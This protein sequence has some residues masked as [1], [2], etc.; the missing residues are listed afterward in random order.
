MV[1]LSKEGIL[2]FPRKKRRMAWYVEVL[3]SE[4]RKLDQ[5]NHAD[6]ENY[7]DEVRK[8][9]MELPFQ[10]ERKNLDQQAKEG[11]DRLLSDYQYDPEHKVYK[12]KRNEVL[13]T[14]QR[15]ST[16]KE[17]LTCECHSENS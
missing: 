6:L 14:S 5:I 9:Q 3:C 1:K 7:R 2:D 12:R 11:L 15:S 8:K 16:N 4:L 10:W 17:L 13:N